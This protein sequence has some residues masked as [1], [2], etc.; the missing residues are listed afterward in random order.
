MLL[1]NGSAEPTTA[2]LALDAEVHKASVVGILGCS[3]RRLLSRLRERWERLLL[4]LLIIHRGLER[5]KIIGS[6]ALSTLVELRL[7]MRLL[8]HLLHLLHTLL[9]LL[10]LQLVLPLH[11]LVGLGLESCLSLWLHRLLLLLWL[12]YHIQ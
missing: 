7:H 2:W 3:L 12:R 10:L 6:L 9:L 5:T 4:G 1:R 11:E 8:L